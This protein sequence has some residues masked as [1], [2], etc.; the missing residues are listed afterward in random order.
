MKNNVAFFGASITQQQNGYW[1]HFGLKNPDLNVKSFGFGSMHL[2]DAGISYIDNVL[3]FNPEYCFIDWFSTG[4]IKY[5]EDKF[6]EIVEY[7]NTII[8]KFYKNG[9]KLVFLTFPDKTVDK[10]EIYIKINDYLKSINVPFLDIS[11]T[12]DNNINEILRDGIHTTP[13]GSEEYARLIND[14]F[15]NVDITIP[16]VY[17]SETKYCTIRSLSINSKITDFLKLSGPCEVI[18]ISQTIGPYTGLL[19]IDG[20][21]INNWDR[22]CY[23]ERKMVNLKFNVREETIIKIQQDDFDKTSCEV[24]GNWLN[25]K[26]LNLETIYYV[27]GELKIID[28][29]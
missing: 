26:Y 15:H 3:E 18:G 17:P 12:F 14:Y 7:I 21:I 5:N 23:Y 6:D 2:N 25:I 8:H 22:W 13:Y 11:N 20:K 29:K 27:N 4:Y 1:F 16:E 28:F 24:D 19:D 9:T 10:T